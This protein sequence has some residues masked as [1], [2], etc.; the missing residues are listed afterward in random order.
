MKKLFRFEDKKSKERACRIFRAGIQLLFFCL[1]PSAFTAAF[2]GVRY[3]ATQ[4]GQT[5]PLVMTSFVGTLCGLCLFTIVFGRFFCGFACAFGS[6]GDALHALYQTICRRLKRKPLR[7][8][9]WFCIL[10]PV[11]RYLVLGMILVL[12]F[13]GNESRLQGYSPWET[14]SLLRIGELPTRQKAAG[15][16]LFF[17]LGIGMCVKERF[18]CQ[19]FCPMGA[20]F[21]LLPV[22]PAFALRQSRESCIT[23]CKACSRR[24]PSAIRLPAD[25]SP[26]TSGDCL[27]CQACIGV[28]PRGNIHSGIKRIRGNEL[29]YTAVRAVALAALLYCFR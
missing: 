7:L 23:G 12:C 5:K 2:A 15:A 11:F 3:L 18:F 27:M 10:A 20:V 4:I 1:F 22:L 19:F 16:L 29:W 26:E 8:P 28:C 14:F 6:L 17:L 21:S 25:G 24:C 9:E 13:T